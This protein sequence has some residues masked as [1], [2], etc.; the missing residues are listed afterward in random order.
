[1]LIHIILKTEKGKKSLSI[2]IRNIEDTYVFCFCHF[3]KMAYQASSDSS[4][5]VF[6]RNSEGGYIPF[7]SSYNSIS[8]NPLPF[9]SYAKNIVL[10]YSKD[11]LERI[12][13]RRI[14]IPEIP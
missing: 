1:M 13:P 4:A 8:D 3:Y 7:F 12:L 6:R 10:L 2:R 11:R 9:H 5:P 14:E